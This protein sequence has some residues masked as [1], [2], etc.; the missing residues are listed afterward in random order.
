[1][2][3]IRSKGFTLVELMIAIVLFFVAALVVAAIWAA[4]HFILKLW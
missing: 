2:K 1:M 3:N 4:I